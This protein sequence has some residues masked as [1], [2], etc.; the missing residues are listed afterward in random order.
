M[1]LSPMW[2]IVLYYFQMTRATVAIIAALIFY[3]L[4]QLFALWITE[5]RVDLTLATEYAPGYSAVR[6]QTIR[7]GERRDLV[8]ATIGHSL[9]H[10]G[11]TNIP[12]LQYECDLYSRP[13]RIPTTL[14]ALW[15]PARLWVSVRVCYGA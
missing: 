7:P 5:S 13:R 3:V 12:G 14:A 8:L 10:V 2:H 4:L 11:P 9:G 1:I 15:L 6:F